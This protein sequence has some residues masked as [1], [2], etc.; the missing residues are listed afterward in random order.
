M[1]TAV[2]GSIFSN[3]LFRPLSETKVTA[4]L[5]L[6]SQPGMDPS[7]GLVLIL[8]GQPSK[9]MGPCPRRKPED[10][11]VFTLLQNPA[12]WLERVSLVARADRQVT[13]LMEMVEFQGKELRDISVSWFLL[14]PFSLNVS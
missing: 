12:L 5:S 10:T 9:A 4:R 1:K 7:P 14:I 6:V 13:S 8:R 3:A 2:L 11:C